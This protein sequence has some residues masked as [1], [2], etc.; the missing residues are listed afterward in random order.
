MSGMGL[1]NLLA[2]FALFDDDPALVNRLEDEFAKITPAQ[3]QKTADQFLR[4][5]NRTILVV[6]PKPE[7]AAGAGDR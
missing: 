6:E 2:S 5:T 1:A 3:I 7:S 4:P